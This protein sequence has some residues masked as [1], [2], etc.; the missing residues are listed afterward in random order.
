MFEK[1]TRLKLRFA[2]SNGMISIED[3]WDLSLSS[4][5]ELAK[6]LNREIQALE[7][8]DFI[9]TRRKSNSKLQLKFDIVR[10]IIDIKLAER[11]AAALKTKN[12]ARIAQLKDILAD[13]EDAKMK[14]RSMA[15]IQEEIDAL[16]GH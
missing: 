1:G 12:A 16:E 15:A 10:H 7:E 5:N 3:L 9:S 8:E 14:R 4:L 11:D 6:K 13:K 2:V